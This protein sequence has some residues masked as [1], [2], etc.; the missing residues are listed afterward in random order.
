[1]LSVLSKETLVI[2]FRVVVLLLGAAA[3]SLAAG[4]SR[5]GAALS[6]PWA[7]RTVPPPADGPL[8]ASESQRLTEG[9]VPP[10]YLSQRVSGESSDAR[11][12]DGTE[13]RHLCLT[14]RVAMGAGRLVGGGGG[15]PQHQAARH[16]MIACLLHFQEV[17]VLLLGGD[18]GRVS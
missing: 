5:R 14:R 6:A 12:C 17:I 15:V 11:H 7:T 9:P 18:T 3:A 2:C 10:C 16:W 1:M 8:R 13:Q 4:T